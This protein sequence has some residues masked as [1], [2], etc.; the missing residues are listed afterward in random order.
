MDA[1]KEHVT[2]LSLHEVAAHREHVINIRK[3]EVTIKW[4]E[5]IN[6]KS[7][8]NHIIITRKESFVIVIVYNNHIG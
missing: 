2:V 4:W 3:E 6:I 8:L 1:C 5:E 7:V